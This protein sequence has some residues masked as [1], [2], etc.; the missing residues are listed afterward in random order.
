MEARNLLDAAPYDL[1][2]L[3]VLKQALDETWASIA[4]VMLFSTMQYSA[5]VFGSNPNGCS[6]RAPKSGHGGPGDRDGIPDRQYAR[7]C[8]WLDK[9][10]WAPCDD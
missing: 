10:G 7:F 6:A 2:T 9:H 1:E 4:S 8:T 3:E 5:G